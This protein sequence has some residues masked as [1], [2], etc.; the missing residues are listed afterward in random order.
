MRE[1]IFD[2]HDEFQQLKFGETLARSVDNKSCVIFLQGDLGAG[3]TTLVRGFLR[4][5]GVSEKVKSPTYTLVEVYEFADIKVLHIDLYRLK[6]PEEITALSLR[7]YMGEK[8]IF[9]IEWPEK[10]SEKLPRPDLV[11]KLSVHHDGR[12]LN[13]TAMTSHGDEILQKMVMTP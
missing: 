13:F 1:C 11:C 12:R 2:I 10:A 6:N 7:D 9:I 8:T 5:M 3:K 4:G